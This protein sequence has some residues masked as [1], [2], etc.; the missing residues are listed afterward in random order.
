MYF[1]FYEKT[2]LLVFIVDT[3]ICFYALTKTMRS[4]E[5]NKQKYDNDVK[6]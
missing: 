3:Q 2:K 1:M 6:N 5:K 4:S